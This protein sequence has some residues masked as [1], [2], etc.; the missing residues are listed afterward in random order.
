ML[1]GCADH[2]IWMS[3]EPSG[4]GEEREICVPGVEEQRESLG[5]QSER[6]CLEEGN[7]LRSYLFGG[8]DVAA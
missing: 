5:G 8:F 7:E 1:G 2:G 3:L 4:F 6:K